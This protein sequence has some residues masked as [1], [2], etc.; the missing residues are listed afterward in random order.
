MNAVIPVGEIDRRTYL[1]SSDISAVLGLSP[2]ATPLDVYLAK[3]GEP[4]QID[5]DKERL[6]RRGKR[7]EP[8]VLEMLAEETGIAIAA[9]NCRYRDP[10]HPFLAAEI[11]AEAEIDGERVNIEVKTVHPFAADQ[12]G[13][14]D[15]DE[16]PI[17]YAAQAMYGLMVTGRRRTMFAVLFGSDNL[18]TYRIDRDEDT[19][20]GIREKAVRFWREHV[21]AEIPPEPIVLEDV[22]RLMRRDQDT[23]FEAD[24]S[25][26]ELVRDFDLAKAQARAATERA[27]EIKFHIGR[28][29]LG[30]PLVSTPSRQPKHV[31]QR[32]GSPI[33]TIGYQEQ[34][35]IDTDAI[36]RLHPE[37]AAACTRTSRF[38]RFDSPRKRS[39]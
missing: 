32:A 19:I 26:A 14:M 39:K 25:L 37:I 34:G 30:E 10:E 16:I 13:E 36:R 31:I 20:S 7:L 22:Y 38:F 5:A 23:I 33:L 8:V 18:T 21:E 28:E 27:E 1:G 24:E 4:R 29:V 9:R 2:W 17:Q 6:F 15:T 3:I 35:R 11:D 12:F